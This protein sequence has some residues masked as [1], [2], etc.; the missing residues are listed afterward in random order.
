MFLD[1]NVFVLLHYV[2][3]HFLVVLPIEVSQTPA[4]P[5]VTAVVVKEEGEKIIRN[6]S[7]STCA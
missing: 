5:I 4:E 1:N 6:S 7:M 3:C 2:F